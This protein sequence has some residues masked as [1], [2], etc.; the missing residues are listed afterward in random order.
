MKK[1]T[2][3][4]FALFFALTVTTQVTASDASMGGETK[5][6]PYFDPATVDLK[7]IMADPPADGSAVT[8]KEIQLILEMQQL[9]T[10]EQVARIQREVHLNV[11]LFDTVFGPWFKTDS[12]PAT[13]HLFDRVNATEHPIIESGKK[14]WHRPRPPLQDSSVHPPIDLPKNDSYPSGHSTVGT[15]DALI[16]VQLAPDLEGKLLGRGDQI[17]QDRIIAGV[18]FPSDVVAGKMLGYALFLKLMAMPE[19]TADLDK[20]KAEIA[21]ARASANG[22]KP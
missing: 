8:L 21:A 14:F 16:L 3:L 7:T 5:A 19:F 20:A 13:A 17:G 6:A 1:F 2:H 15:L 22:S 11:D 9:R 10:P 12:L 4:L 18:H